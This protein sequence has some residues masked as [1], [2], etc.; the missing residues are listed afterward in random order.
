M[1]LHQTPTRVWDT[2]R[3]EKKRRVESVQGLINGKVIPTDDLTAILEKLIVSGDRVVMEGNNQKQADFLSRSLAEVDPAK[4]HDLHMIMPSVG[5]A[6][7]LDIFE[8]GIAR[9]LD[10]AFSGTQSLRISQLLEDGQLEIGAI[11]TYIELYS[12][13]YVDLVPN[14]ALVAGFKA[15]RHGNLYTGPSTEDTPALVEAAAFKNGLVIAQV[16]ELVD[17]ETDLP[18]VDIPGSWIDFVVV[19]DKP[20]FIEPLFTRDPRLIKPVHV[21]MGMMAIKGIYAKHQVQSLNHGI[22]FNTAAIE[23]LLPT[24]GEQL[25]LKG[26]I[27]KHWT[28]NPH[29]TLIPAIESGWVETV[30]CF[31]GELGME[32]YIA[33][34]PDIFFTGNDGSMRSNRAFCQMA[35][36]YAVDMFIGSTLQIDGMAHSSTVT[37]GRLS[38]FGGAPNMGHD[39]HGRRHATPAWLDMIEEPDPLARGRKL[40]VQMVETFQAGAKPTFVEKLDAIDVAKES[41]MPLAPVM[42]YGDDVTHVLTEE[43]IAYLY[44]ARSLE[45]RRAMVAAVAGI[46]DIGLGVD[47]KRVAELRREGK[48][49]FPEDMGIRRTD[50]TRSLLAAGSVSDLVEWS[51]GL[52]NPPAKFRSW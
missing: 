15:D 48:V 16:N 3:Q 43:G 13:L 11:H 49:V 22:G 32:D 25:G 40:V 7:H 30:H 24:Y 33:A 35:G 21:L 38:G 8:K 51:D 42:I 23:L 37:R 41:G 34:R 52:Y 17:D 39:P 20:F 12:R 10:F 6:E 44:R 31:G 27:C 47:A 5:R 45:E 26:K 9:K 50:A 14:V 2:R 18:R 29:P 46:T 19:A 4:V 1:S 36:Q 28:L